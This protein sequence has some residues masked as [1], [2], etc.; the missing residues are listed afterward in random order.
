MDVAGAIAREIDQNNPNTRRFGQQR[1]WDGA[2]RIFQ[3]SVLFHESAEPNGQESLKL[4]RSTEVKH[5]AN[6][7][8]TRLQ[9]SYIVVRFFESGCAAGSKIAADQCGVMVRYSSFEAMVT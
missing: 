4:T 1:S 7:A 8:V 2:E 6:A 9:V 3:R 5:S